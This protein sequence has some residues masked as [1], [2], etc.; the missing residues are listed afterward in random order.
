[1]KTFDIKYLLDQLIENLFIK[2]KFK[3]WFLQ[4]R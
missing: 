2:L 4:K 1:M 3:N